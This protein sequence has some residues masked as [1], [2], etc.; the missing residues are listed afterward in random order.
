VLV[1]FCLAIL[2][3]ERLST[4]T[5]PRHRWLLWLVSQLALP[6]LSCLITLALEL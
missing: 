4:E 2:W 6:V 3:E 5:W 1:F